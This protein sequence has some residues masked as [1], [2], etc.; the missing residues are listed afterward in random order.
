MYYL[1]SPLSTSFHNTS[2]ANF[3]SLYL[4]SVHFTLS[5]SSEIEEET[6][7]TELCEDDGHTSSCSWGGESN[8]TKATPAYCIY[9]Q[10]KYG[11]KTHILVPN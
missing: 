9:L 7:A 8:K 10:L 2:F 4:S 11:L 5:L 3:I 1:P 6:A